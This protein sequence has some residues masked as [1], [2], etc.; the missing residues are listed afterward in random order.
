MKE[1]NEQ[2]LKMA[3]TLRQQGY[4]I[5]DIATE[6]NIP[7]TTVDNGL[8]NYRP[9]ESEDDEGTSKLNRGIGSS[10]GE[11]SGL[12]EA[13]LNHERRMAEYEL[14]Q[15]EIKLQRREL[16]LREMEAET[17]REMLALKEK[18]MD[19]AASNEKERVED[20]KLRYTRKFNRLVRELLDNCGDDD[21]W[22][23]EEIDDYLERAE[24]LSKKIKQF[25]DYHL[26]E[27]ESMAIVAN[28]NS[29]IT[30]VEKSKEEKS[31]I[32]SSDVC[33]E[34]DKKQ[35]RKIK[36]WTITNF[37]DEMVDEDNA[38]E[39]NADEDNEDEDNEDE[40]DE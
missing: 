1:M 35:K 24:L 28:L 2:E 13:R 14:R 26:L 31:G 27:D 8:R 7:K 10:V 15:E 33:F 20:R 40:D 22:T 32:F 21:T 29:L 18:Q 5:R 6:L 30:Y 39:D 34:A 17:Q 11:S 25:C 9:S 23:G 37:E 12:H 16:E 3:Y 19:Q 36:S 4:S 38:D